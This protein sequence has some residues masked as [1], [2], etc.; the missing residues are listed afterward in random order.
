M[1][2]VLVLVTII[3]LRARMVVVTLYVTLHRGLKLILLHVSQYYKFSNYKTETTIIII[4]KTIKCI[5]HARLL[6][7]NMS[8]VCII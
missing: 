1:Y 2:K 4:I 6:I 3:V 7:F 8:I 5:L